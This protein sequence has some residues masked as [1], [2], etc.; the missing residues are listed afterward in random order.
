MQKKLAIIICAVIAVALPQLALAD[1]SH[2]QSSHKAAWQNDA[3]LAQMQSRSM[4]QESTAGYGFL[5]GMG[6]PGAAPIQS[7][8]G[9][10]IPGAPN[11]M[12]AEMAEPVHSLS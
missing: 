1:T 9:K 11:G 8:D 7:I 10:K 5:E 6:N 12:L 2:S 4:G 3:W